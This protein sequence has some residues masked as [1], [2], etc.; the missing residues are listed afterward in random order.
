VNKV[1]EVAVVDPFYFVLA[2]N[3]HF[4]LVVGRQR[5]AHDFDRSVEIR[6]HA[7]KGKIA[8]IAKLVKLL[9]EANKVLGVVSATEREVQGV[10]LLVLHEDVLDDLAFQ[11]GELGTSDLED[12]KPAALVEDGGADVV[13]ALGVV[14]AY[15]GQIKFLDGS[16]ID[17]CPRDA[18]AIELLVEHRIRK[19]NF[20]Q[21]GV[22]LHALDDF[23]EV[24]YV[25]K[26]DLD[27][28]ERFKNRLLFEELREAVGCLAGEAGLFEP[29][30]DDATFGS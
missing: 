18:L 25:F 27:Q 14:V 3:K 2:H 7:I 9:H 26:R 1:P 22:E 23:F 12:I 15:V 16:R 30:I 5:L 11:V 28:P 8:N 24:I 21:L 4:Q 29:Q 19:Q 17:E 13:K 10:E 20:G 6:L